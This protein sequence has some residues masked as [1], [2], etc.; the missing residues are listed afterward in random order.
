MTT[1]NLTD[2]PGDIYRQFKVDC[3]N[4]G[5]TIKSAIFELMSVSV[6]SARQVGTISEVR[7]KHCLRCDT[8]WQSRKPNPIECP[9]CKS[10]SWWCV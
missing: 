4:R 2:V 10:R 1:I 3:A 9:A 8:H 6:G 7:P 5:V